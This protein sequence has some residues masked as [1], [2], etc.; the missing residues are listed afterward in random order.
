MSFIQFL[1]IIEYSDVILIP[2]GKVVYSI[3]LNRGHPFLLTILLSR[4]VE[5]IVMFVIYS[6]LYIY[7]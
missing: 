1:S 7:V 6:C 3:N 2:S 5:L 4:I